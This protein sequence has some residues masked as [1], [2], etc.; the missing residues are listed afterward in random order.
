MVIRNFNEFLSVDGG[1]VGNVVREFMLRN[2]FFYVNYYFLRIFL[3]YVFYVIFL[4]GDEM[5]VSFLGMVN[6]IIK[7]IKYFRVYDVYGKDLF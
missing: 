5:K 1:E 6:I 4:F 2:L 7:L 3:S